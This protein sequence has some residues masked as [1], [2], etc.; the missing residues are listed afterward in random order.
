MKRELV[1]T[2]KESEEII[3]FPDPDLEKAIKDT[4]DFEIGYC[5]E[6]FNAVFLLQVDNKEDSR[7]DVW[8]MLFYKETI[9]FD[10]KT[11]TLDNMD[12]AKDGK[13]AFEFFKVV[14]G[15]FEDVINTSV[16]LIKKYYEDIK[17]AEAGRRAE[18]DKDLLPQE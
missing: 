3:P 12:E 13:K 15:N 10:E 16:D 18:I 5:P 4:F 8:Q 11:I 1:Y 14:E 9:K 6:G 7:K 17:N 2:K